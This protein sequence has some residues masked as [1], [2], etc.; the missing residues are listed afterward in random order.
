MM[1]MEQARSKFDAYKSKLKNLIVLVS[2]FKWF[3]A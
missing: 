2:I 1:N 3:K